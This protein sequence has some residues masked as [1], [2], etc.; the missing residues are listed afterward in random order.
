MSPTNSKEYIRK[1]GEKHR[2]YYA[3]QM[4]KWYWSHLDA[5]RVRNQRARK[6]M[7]PY[8]LVYQRLYDAIRRGKKM[9]VRRDEKRLI[10]RYTSL[11][12]LVKKC[13][14]KGLLDP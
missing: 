13:K 1:W 2:G 4:K 14:A 7:R 5:A 12:R 9:Q 6:K 8:Q 11:Q 3:R 10:S